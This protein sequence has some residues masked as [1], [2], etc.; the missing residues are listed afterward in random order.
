MV[1]NVTYRQLCCLLNSKPPS[2]SQSKGRS[3]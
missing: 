2:K 1:L 3:K